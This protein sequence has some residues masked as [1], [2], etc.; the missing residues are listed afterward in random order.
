MVIFIY[1]VVKIMFVRQ[2]IG[3]S[4]IVILFYVQVHSIMSCISQVQ[5]YYKNF[6]KQYKVI[7]VMFKEFGLF[8]NP[9]KFYW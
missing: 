8:K 4:K 9:V 3:Q 5:A 6:E 2:S 1:N 7:L